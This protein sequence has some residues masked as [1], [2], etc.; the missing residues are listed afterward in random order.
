MNYSIRPG[1]EALKPYQT[2]EPNFMVK[3]DANERPCNLPTAVWKQVCSRLGTAAFNRYPDIGTK[4]LCRLIADSFNLESE[5]VLIG[6]GSSEILF[7]VC[8]T[9]GGSNRPIIFPYPSFS[10]YEVYA[11]LADSPVIKVSLEKDFSLDIDNV[12]SAAKQATLVILCNPNNPTGLTMKLEDIERIVAE[13]NCPVVVDEA[14][15]EFFGESALPLLAKYPQLIIVRT[16]SKA[17]GLAAARV[18]YMLASKE[19]VKTIGAVMLPYHVNSLSLVA[20]QVVWSMQDEFKAAINQIIVERERIFSTLAALKNIEVYS[21]QANFLLFKV[22][23]DSFI[24]A[25]TLRGALAQR[26]IGIRG[27]STLELLDCLRVTVGSSQE[28]TL[29]IEAITSILCK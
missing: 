18:G 21:S 13:V 24:N 11:T 27:F 29:F 3:L 9:F 22:L 4:E 12:I 16:F 17:Y 7:T 14:Y 10:M 1:Y 5:Q 2:E 15:Y 26:G 25:A 8:Q 28:N 6:N 20:A 19:M 23:P